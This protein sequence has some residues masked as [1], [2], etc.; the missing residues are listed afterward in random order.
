MN[1]QD[2]R[3]DKTV[4]LDALKAAVASFATMGEDEYCIN[5]RMLAKRL[6]VTAEYL[7]KSYRAER[8]KR[9]KALFPPPPTGGVENDSNTRTPIDLTLLLEGV[10][11]CSKRCSNGCSKPFDSNTCALYLAGMGLLESEDPLAVIAAEVTDRGYAGD[12]SPVQL[13]YLA[14]ASRYQRRPLNLYFRGQPASGKNYAIERALDLIPKDFY[15][16]LTGSSERALIY[17]AEEFRH[18]H[19]IMAEADSIPADGPAAS[20]LRSIAEDGECSYE[21]VEQNPETGKFETRRIV[22]KGPTGFI[23]TGIRQLEAQMASRT[24]ER[25]IS[26]EPDQTRAIVRAEA[27]DA[28][29]EQSA[30]EPDN[31][32]FFAYQYWLDACGEKRVMVP[33]AAVLAEKVHVKSVRMRR[34]FRQLLSAIRAVA[35][36]TQR[37]RERAPDGSIVASLDDYAKVRALL[38]PT[39]DSTASDGITPAIRATVEAVQEGEEA[40]ESDLVEKLGLAKSTISY[41]VRRALFGGWLKNSETRKGFPARLSRGGSL[42]EQVLGLPE[43]DEVSKLFELERLSNTHSNG[44]QPIGGVAQ[45]EGVFECSNDFQGT[46]GEGETGDEG[47]PSLEDEDDYIEI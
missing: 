12:T 4:K 31:T 7:D 25:A 28:Q 38:I 8:R 36:L 30:A 10:G 35:F 45:T 39:F 23:T 46:G 29:K 43:V 20:M 14:L 13:T 34:D 41:R 21:T 40:S 42:P 18:R 9:G 26:D 5:R 15:Y 3:P 22:K 2:D 44:S 19:I 37:H 32:E 17:T 6:G 11:G 16:K 24:L 47:Q 1:D 27:V 33:F